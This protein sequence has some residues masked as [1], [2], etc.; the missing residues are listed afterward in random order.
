MTQTPYFT[1]ELPVMIDVLGEGNGEGNEIIDGCV[2]VE[3]KAFDLAVA[4]SDSDDAFMTIVLAHGT[5]LVKEILRIVLSEFNL[6]DAKL[7]LRLASANK[8]LDPNKSLEDYM[9]QI[10]SGGT[11]LILHNQAKN[12]LP[13]AEEDSVINVRVP[14]EPVVSKGLDAIKSTHRIGIWD[15][16]DDDIP[17][18]RLING[19][20]HVQPKVTGVVD[21]MGE[22]WDPSDSVDLHEFNG[23]SSEKHVVI[24]L[25]IGKRTV[26][27]LKDIYKTRMENNMY[28]HRL[29]SCSNA[30]PLGRAIVV[31][32]F[33]CL[34][35]PKAKKY[36][37]VLAAENADSLNKKKMVDVDFQIS[38]LSN[39]TVSSIYDRVTEMTGLS[40]GLYKLSYN[41]ESLVI[42]YSHLKNGF[43]LGGDLDSFTEVPHIYMSFTGAS[44]VTIQAVLTSELSRLN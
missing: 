42:V 3:G 17:I 43:L 40:G 1:M 29:N 34:K 38:I 19:Y 4:S 22:I 31:M 8:I 10:L 12:K 27:K 16:K 32:N 7:D 28:R 15:H 2:E 23:D 11:L 21:R 6:S 13:F 44:S 26:K 5:Q 25:C 9:D 36:Y 14:D 18:D 30:K 20:L 39:D 33:Y 41:G 37:H 35:T 24:P